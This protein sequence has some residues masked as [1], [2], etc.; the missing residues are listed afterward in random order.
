MSPPWCGAVTTYQYDPVGQLVAMV[1]EKARGEL[2]RHDPTGNLF[3]ASVGAKARE[4]GKGN[5]LVRRG[6]TAYAWDGDGRLIEKVVKDPATGSEQ[7][8][9]YRW[10]GAGLLEAATAPDG[11]LVELMYDPFARRL[12]KRVSRH[13]AGEGRPT[14]VAL[15]RFVWDGDVLVHEIRRSARASGDPVVVEERT[16]CF[17]EDGFEPVA[18]QESRRDD[19]GQEH[20]AWFHYVN[21]L[22]GTPERLIGADGAIAC[23]LR[24]SAWGSADV[25]PGAKASTPI[26]FQG[27]YEDAETG[28]SYN[29]FRYYDSETGTFISADPIGLHGGTNEFR[30]PVNM[31]SW[32]DPLGLAAKKKGPRPEPRRSG[33]NLN[34]TNEGGVKIESHGTNDVDRPAHA[35]VCSPGQKDCRI[36]PNGKPIAG[37]RELT[38]DEKA[39]VENNLPAIRKELNKVGRASAR[40]EK[41]GSLPGANNT[42]KK[43]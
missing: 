8:F 5:R 25:L 26:R 37:Q 43:K 38:A 17:E 29:R 41:A 6:D 1:P 15:T 24:L 33:K 21:D 30:A 11:T 19:V 32:I 20:G 34:P 4:Y 27:Q 3:E 42:S 9:R 36:G 23:D 28:L 39:V 2:F 12:Q 22:N 7:R 10:N 18:H 14:L 31:Q 35:H 13:A 40:M 16:Y